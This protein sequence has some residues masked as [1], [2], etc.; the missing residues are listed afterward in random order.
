[1]LLGSVS[2]TVGTAGLTA[3]CAS[4]GALLGLAQSAALEFIRD[5]VRVNV[6]SPAL[7]QTA[8]AESYASSVSEEGKSE[9]LASHP[10]GIG[11]PED[12]AY[13][14][15][16]LLSDASAWVTGTNLVVDGGYTAR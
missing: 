5:S 16:Y 6:V 12:V 3:Y 1:V 4:K 11:R 15:I 7:V 2:G 9:N 10:M 13:A 14:A 8:L